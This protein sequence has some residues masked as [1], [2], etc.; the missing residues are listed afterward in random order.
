MRSNWYGVNQVI[1][2]PMGRLPVLKLI[3]T[4]FDVFFHV[5]QGRAGSRQ[6]GT[7]WRAAPDPGCRDGGEGDRR[8]GES[9]AADDSAHPT[10]AGERAPQFRYPIRDR[11]ATFSAAFDAVLAAEGIR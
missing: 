5:A 3:R 6:P 7:W 11:D 10:G 9:E 4:D 1:G 2:R 8:A